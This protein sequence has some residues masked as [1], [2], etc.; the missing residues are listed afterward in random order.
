MKV[1]ISGLIYPV[2]MMRYM[3]EELERFDNIELFSIGPFFGD[4]IP[5]SGGLTL[6]RQY[7]KTP[8][9][10]LSGA[11]NYHP[12]SLAD[13][14]PDDIDVWLQVDASWHFASRPPAKKVVLIETDPHCVSGDTMLATDHGI[15]YINEL[16]TSGLID[17]D[18]YV[19][20]NGL[21]LEV[22]NKRRMVKSGGVI[23][24][25]NKPTR[26]IILYGGYE[27]VCTDDHEIESE[28]GFVEA[29]DLKIGDKVVISR[30]TYQNSKEGTSTDYSIGFILGAFQ[31][32]GS[33]GSSD[34]VKFTIGKE[35]KY[36]FGEAIKFHLMRGFGI[37][38][39]TEGKHYTNE[40]TKILQ[41]RRWGF[42]RFLKSVNIKSGNVPV[43]IRTGSKQLFAGYLA[44]LLASDG[45]SSNGLLQFVTKNEQLAKELQTMLLY[46]GMMTRRVPKVTT[47]S[48]YKP[49]QTHWIL[50]INAGESTN[51]LINLVGYIPGK[52]IKPDSRGK[53]EVSGNVQLFEI[54][55]IKGEIKNYP[56][57]RCPEPVYDVI[58]CEGLASFLAN[59]FSVHNC[60]KDSYTV[61]ASYSDIVLCMQSN[62]MIAD[63][64]WW[65]YAVD[66]HWFYPED[67]PIKHDV[68]IIGLQYEQRTRV[69][70]RMRQIGKDVLYDTGIIYDEYR[71]A[72]NSSR[73]AFNWSSLQDLPVRVFEAMGMK[74]PLVTNR[75]PD[76]E[77]LFIENEHYLGFST[78][79]EA[80]EKIKFL[81]D[82]PDFA[83]NM[84][85]KAYKEVMKRHTW[86]TRLEQL[87][88][89]IDGEKVIQYV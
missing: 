45:C 83:H 47:E 42:H 71:N 35:R 39:V 55:D 89:I 15:V 14:I 8:N 76:L 19:I 41:V 43:Y 46:Y 72:Y 18:P 67:L 59:G 37:N 78:V 20:P 57:L 50:Y 58:N 84:A 11:V 27:L 7:V 86:K 28:N 36:E 87:F 3:W 48:S 21:E 75:V 12:Q 33:F 60:I 25:G 73:V 44:G 54:T 85:E 66:N 1:A 26:K 62:Y 56:H 24:K 53:K 16:M 10:P 34:I 77:K 32:D 22:A 51:N 5:W 81:L 88:R 74:R 82:T 52:P 65:P 61:P 4:W 23:Y 40:N 30:G 29:K 13:V 79:D 70:N 2:T 80:E 49:G 69:V 68:C 64:I 6:P 31:G 9:V 38:V 63:D 17:H